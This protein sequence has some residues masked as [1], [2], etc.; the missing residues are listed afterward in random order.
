MSL[1]NLLTRGLLI[2]VHLWVRALRRGLLNCARITENESAA[3]CRVAKHAYDV[4]G[5]TNPT[6]GLKEAQ[7]RRWRRSG[8]L[9]CGR[10]H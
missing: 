9:G 7:R 8:W 5:V 2:V 4:F 10:H 6:F 3:R 1:A